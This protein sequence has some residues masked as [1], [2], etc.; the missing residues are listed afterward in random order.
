[1]QYNSSSTYAGTA[2][3]ATTT[4]GQF[5]FYLLSNVPT[6]LSSQVVAVAYCTG[7]TAVAATPTVDPLQALKSQV[8]PP[9]PPSPP[10][11]PSPPLPSPPPPS[12]PPPEP[13]SPPPPSKEQ[14][15]AP[16]TSAA[17]G[18]EQVRS[19]WTLASI[20]CG[21]NRDLQTFFARLSHVQRQLWLVWLNTE[22]RSSNWHHTQRWHDAGHSDINLSGCLYT[23]SKRC[24]SHCGHAWLDS[25]G[26][27]SCIHPLFDW[28]L[29]AQCYKAFGP[30]ECEHCA[31]W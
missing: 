1:M 12:P 22:R 26:D 16:G 19:S 5:C 4:V 14:T 31:G 17:S 10:M 23:S 18:V 7:G 15:T 27:S 3:G 11:P 25:L 13:P 6:T 29:M 2:G 20:A 24:R 8:S 21:G 28:T 9:P 30:C